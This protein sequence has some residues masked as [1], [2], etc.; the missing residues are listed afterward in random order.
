MPGK[1]P[2]KVPAFSKVL[3]E[4]ETTNP[5]YA[6]FLKSWQQ[7]PDKDK[8]WQAVQVA[9]QA[10]HRNPPTAP[11]FIGAVLGSTLPAKILNDHND[12]VIDQFEKLK[13][14]IA[15]VVTDAD[16]PSDLLRDLQGFEQPLREL[17]RSAF[18]I[19]TR[20][21][22]RKDQDGSSRDRKAF[23]H[24]MF[25]YLHDACGQYLPKQVATMVDILFPGPEDTKRDL[26]RQVRDW[27][28][29]K[30]PKRVV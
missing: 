19:R 12:R 18:D 8:L 25:H 10:D 26:D 1:A 9:A 16:Y 6:V 17:S 27:L 4:C 2:Q 7:H 11:D 3:A 28:P 30:P 13:R 23:V 21:G 20:A 5:R 15:A 29:P 14:K 22:G 24:R